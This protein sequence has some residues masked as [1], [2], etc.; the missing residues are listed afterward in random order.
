MLSIN[1]S[2]RQTSGNRNTLSNAAQRQRNSVLNLMNDSF[3]RMASNGRNQDSPGTQSSMST[4]AYVRTGGNTTIAG[5][6]ADQRGIEGRSITID[7]SGYSQSISGTNGMARSND[8]S[9][10][11]ATTRLPQQM[12]MI[13]ESPQANPTQ[14]SIGSFNMPVG[15]QQSSVVVPT[16]LRQLNT[17]GT[18]HDWDSSRGTPNNSSLGTAQVIPLTPDRLDSMSDQLSEEAYQMERSPSF[19]SSPTRHASGSDMVPIRRPVT[20]GSELAISRPVQHGPVRGRLRTKPYS[21]YE[22]LAK[23]KNFNRSMRSIT[24]RLDV[25]GMLHPEKQFLF[26]VRTMGARNILH[27]SEK[28][29]GIDSSKYFPMIH[30]AMDGYTGEVTLLNPYL[31]AV[32]FEERYSSDLPVA[33][34]ETAWE[35]FD[36]HQT[37]RSMKALYFKLQSKGLLRVRVGSPNRVWYSES[38]KT[39]FQPNSPHKARAIWDALEGVQFNESMGNGTQFK[40]LTREHYIRLMQAL[41]LLAAAQQEPHLPRDVDFA[42][43]TLKVQNITDWQQ[44]PQNFN[45]RSDVE[46]SDY[47]NNQSDAHQFDAPNDELVVQQTSLMTSYADVPQSAQ[48]EANT[49]SHSDE[50]SVASFVQRPKRKFTARPTVLKVNVGARTCYVI[51]FF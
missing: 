32:S 8:R 40:E 27:V 9:R 10:S 39:L 30:N 49:R 23:E 29:K 36:G 50:E 51:R 24:N 28:L 42:G 31:P 7:R 13:T 19:L 38:Y 17:Y 37:V 47:L 2:H 34:Y 26:Y 46:R 21:P 33:S 45:F 43:N 25:V 1:K 5:L 4:F 48:E 18:P 41:D 15:S 14:S 3:T 35:W 16:P 20:Q 6:Q 11:Q 22:K 12:D 44:E